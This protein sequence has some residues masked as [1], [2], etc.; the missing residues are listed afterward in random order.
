MTEHDIEVMRQRIATAKSDRDRWH[1]AG[2]QEKFLESYVVVKALE[3]ELDEM[4]SQQR[5][6]VPR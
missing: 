6:A 4:L 2:P 3:L 1:Q 5:R